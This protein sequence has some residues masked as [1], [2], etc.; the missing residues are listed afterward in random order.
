[1]ME[2][3][4]PKTLSVNGREEPIRYE[5]TAVL[6]AIAAM[7]APDLA[8]D[9]KAYACMYI[10]YENFEEFSTEDYRPAYE[11]ACEFINNGEKE[12]DDGK[13][14]PK[15][16]DFEQDYRVMIPAINKVAGK[17][18]REI[19]DLHWWTFMSWFMEIGECTYSTVLSIRQKKSKGKKLEKWEQEFYASN[20]KLV[21]IQPKYSEKEKEEIEEAERRLIALIDG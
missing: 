4:L 3:G 18:I 9:E 11:A 8:N 1:M 6:D 16:I 14:H 10:L 5:Y 19:P 15:L 20:K 21:D 17:E 2:I 12:E 7:N 13:F